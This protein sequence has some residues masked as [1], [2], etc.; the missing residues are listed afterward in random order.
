MNGAD[1][2]VTACLRRIGRGKDG[3]RSLAREEACA[4]MAAILDGR[5]EDLALGGVLLALRMKG[6]AVEEI[7][8]FLDALEPRL[9][10]A[11]ALSLPWVVLPSYNGARSQPNLLPLLALLL[12]RAGLPVLV[13]GQVS[14]PAA[15]ARPRV[16]SAA[17]FDALG[18]APCGDPAQAGARASARVP[19][20][21]PLAAICP[22]L[23]RLVALRAR[24]GVRNVAHTL[25]KLLQPVPG[26][27]LLVT[28][29]THPAF[30]QLQAELFRM[31]GRWAMSLRG[32]DGEGVISARR[33]QAVDLWRDGVCTQVL[34]AQALA[35]PQLS[36]PAPDRDSTARWIADVLAGV[37]PVPPAIAGQ[38][39][40]I[41]RAVLGA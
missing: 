32:T 22:Q 21:L 31:T 9:Q 1:F 19:A 36:L 39:T 23:S 3:A 4:L 5:V 13:H 6:E 27:A 37:A 30:G 29:Y 12:A 41:R 24:L 17:I 11:P 20:L 25:V 35:D 14:E 26:P 16:D 7:A 15:A 33:A 18:I 10:R 28:S 38:V 2:S 40:A 8:G 34:E